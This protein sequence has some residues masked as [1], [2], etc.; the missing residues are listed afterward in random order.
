V[1]SFQR[2]RHAEEKLTARKQG[3]WQERMLLRAAVFGYIE[4]FYN[5]QR[6]HSPVNMLS[7]ATTNNSRCSAV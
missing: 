4:A 6:W 5:R 1:E 2:E 3:S 7:P